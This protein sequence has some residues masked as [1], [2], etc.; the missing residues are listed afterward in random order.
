[1]F[2]SIKEIARIN[3]C[4]S[5]LKKDNNLFDYEGFILFAKSNIEKY[6]L[7]EKDSDLLVNG[8]YSGNLINEYKETLKE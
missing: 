1:M 3:S 4:I 7:I 6:H 5:K 2:H 8:W